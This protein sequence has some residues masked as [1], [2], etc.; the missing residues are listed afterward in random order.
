[1]TLRTS[2]TVAAV[3]VSAA[4][5]PSARADFYGVSWLEGRVFY[6]DESSLAATFVTSIGPQGRANAM[7]K[8]ASGT[9]LIAGH[10][11]DSTPRLWSFDPATH[12]L[13]QGAA[14]AVDD[15]RAMAVSP[16][17]VLYAAVNIGSPLHSLYTV[18]PATGQAAL[19]GINSH[20]SV[21]GMAFAPDGTL[22]GWAVGAGLVRIDPLTGAT[23]DVNGNL[24]EPGNFY[25]TL[26]TGAAGELRGAGRNGTVGAA[27]GVIDTGTG[28]SGP[29]A[30][31]SFPPG[32]PLTYTDIRGMEWVPA[33]GG[34]L[35]FVACAACTGARRRR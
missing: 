10:A 27:I 23:V 5:A 19:V 22:Y 31:I 35:L 26:F 2:L 15:V 34:L 16:S 17:G 14:L 30:Y 25:Q 3:A 33:P 32:T 4:V 29:P 13:T 1:M 28:L 9:L 12:A 6:V 8:D 11:P 20:T 7:A 18:N 24:S 21:Q